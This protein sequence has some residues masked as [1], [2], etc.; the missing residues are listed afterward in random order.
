MSTCLPHLH[1]AAE[2][3]LTSVGQCPSVLVCFIP[4]AIVMSPGWYGSGRGGCPKKRS[5]TYGSVM[6]RLLL[7]WRRCTKPLV[8]HQSCIAARWSHPP[9]PRHPAPPAAEAE[10]QGETLSI[11]AAAA[12]AS[13]VARHRR[14][15]LPLSL[16]PIHLRPRAPVAST[17][18]CGPLCSGC[19]V[20]QQPP[21]PCHRCRT[22]CSAAQVPRAGWAPTMAFA[23]SLWYTAGLAH[24]STSSLMC[25]WG[26]TAGVA[27]CSSSVSQ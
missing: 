17:C 22:R 6:L 26:S 14:A 12:A 10:G 8:A 16:A 5:Y 19:A 20:A 24:T 2:P 27:A 18:F 9:A 3:L 23:G 4:A 11:P 21:P 7:P 25:L 15:A 1:A 13:A